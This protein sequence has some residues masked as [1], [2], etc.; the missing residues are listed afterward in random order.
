VPPALAHVLAE[1]GPL[2]L[3]VFVFSMNLGIPVPGHMAYVTSV[4]LAAEGKMSLPLVIGF[5]APAAF[6]GSWLGFVIGQR[7]GHK[8]VVRHGPRVGLSAARLAAMERF[9]DR[10]GGLAV[11]FMRFVIV[12][13][14]FGSLFA[15]ASELATGRFLAASAAGAAV[16]A[17][18]YAV[19]GSFF[20]ESWHAVEDRLGVLGLVA[21]GVLALAGLAHIVWLR[22][23]RKQ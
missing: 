21:L 14:C 12:V 23:R 13:R 8:L 20:R 22:R 7:G 1:Y 19:A 16:W 3:A 6:L 10:H 2:I 5:S 15:G 9:F 17:A 18:S 4:V 11:F